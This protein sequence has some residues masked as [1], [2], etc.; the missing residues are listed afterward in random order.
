MEKIQFIYEETTSLRVDKYLSEVME[1]MTRTRLQNLI[2]K[3][4]ITVNEKPV[5]TNYK[6]VKN[7]CIQVRMEEPKEIDILPENIPI[8]IIYEDHDVLIVNKERGMVVHPGPGNYEHT[9]VNAI[10]Y[11]CKER[12]SSINGVIRPGIVHRIDKDTSGLLIICKNDIAHNDIAS[13]LKAHTIHRLYEALVY[14]N[15]TEN[16]GTIEGAIGRSMNDRKKMAIHVKNG[17]EATTHYK[18]VERFAMNRF[19]KVECKLETGRTHQIRVHMQSIGN[20]LIGD[21]VYGPKKPKFQTKGQMLH[22]KTIGFIHPTTKE[23]M[24][25]T[26]EPPEDYQQM[27]EKLRNM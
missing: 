1:D 17:K 3:E 25:F 24:E 10:M 16:E 23:Y 11:H 21:P 22:A 18:V 6:L 26:I 9:L 8:E 19:T 2:K 27:V 15:I 7:D 12:L 20:P 5:K 4:Q 14:Q 13:Q